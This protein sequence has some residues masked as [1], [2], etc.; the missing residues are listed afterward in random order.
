MTPAGPPHESKVT[1]RVAAV[2]SRASRPRRVMRLLSVLAMSFGGA[3]ACGRTGLELLADVG[4]DG[5]ASGYEAGEASGADAAPDAAAD[6]V[7]P[8]VDLDAPSGP[9]GVVADAA[10]DV[11]SCIEAAD[12]GSLPPSCAPGG[13]G[14]TNCGPGGSGCE[15]C[16]ASLE[17][18]GGTYYRTYTYG[19]TSSYAD[20][21]TVSGFRLDK[22][23][24]TVGRFRQ[25]IAA[26]S[27]GYYPPN[28]SGKHTHLNEGLGLAVAPNVDAGQTYESGWDA[29]DWNN[30]PYIDPTTANLQ[31]VSPFY[32]WTV[33][34]AANEN[35]P[36]NC[37]TWWESYAFCI[38]DGGF[39]PS[40]AEWEYAA[41]GGSQ[42]LE[43]PWGNTA[44]SS[45]TDPGTANQYAIYDCNYPS[46]SGSC[47]GVTSIA[48]VGFASLGVGRWGQFDLAGEVFEWNLDWYATPYADPSSDSAYLTT[49]SSRVVR[50]ASFGNSASY[51]LPPTRHPT[52]PPPRADGRGSGARG[53][54]DLASLSRPANE[55]A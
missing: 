52:S 3:L 14:M 21:A 11:P 29:T 38:W 35:L 12:S 32:T 13:P 5:G 8:D 51:L 43:Y 40:E 49:A 23:L 42:Q 27:A 28:G 30:A 44:S 17:V 19:E 9:D 33:T 10:A 31:C 6:I 37:A 53:R 39:L 25:F 26:W 22:Y 15:S 41:A 24:V 20:P 18:E 47:S 45:P 54:R 2:G 34:A 1:G 46:G 7:V 50:G 55:E 36:I 16:C 4:N 48:P